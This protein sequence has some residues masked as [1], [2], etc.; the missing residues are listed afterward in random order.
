MKDNTIPLL[1]RKNVSSSIIYDTYQDAINAINSREKEKGQLFFIAYR[2]LMP[3]YNI[4]DKRVDVILAYAYG[5]QKSEY[6]ILNFCTSNL[7]WGVF[8]DELPSI[9]ILIHE[10]QFLYH[11]KTNHKWFL[12]FSLDGINRTVQ[13]LDAK[14]QTF[15]DIS[16]GNLWVSSN[17]KKVRCL[18]DVC[19]QEETLRILNGLEFNQRD[20]KET[21]P[22]KV[23]YIRNKPKLSEL[24]TITYTIRKEE[25][26]RRTNYNLYWTEYGTEEEIITGTIQLD[27]NREIK[28]GVLS[29]V[30]VNN[31]NL[32]PSDWNIGDEFLDLTIGGYEQSHVYIYMEP[33]V[34]RYT[35]G[36]GIQINNNII[37]VKV[38][39]ETG[40]TSNISWNLVNN[41][42]SGAM[43]S[44]DH[45]KITDFIP[46]NYATNS[47]LE[48]GE[49]IAGITSSTKDIIAPETT[50][51]TRGVE[52]ID[53]ILPEQSY[54]KE[55]ST[56]IGINGNNTT[57]IYT[58][59]LVST[60][61]N[62]YKPGNEVEG[63]K[64]DSTTG[65]VVEDQDYSLVWCRCIKSKVNTNYNEPI[66]NNGYVIS[67]ATIESVA[68]SN[69][70]PD[71]GNI[72]TPL[73][74]STTIFG[75]DSYIILEN[76]KVLLVSVLTTDLETLCI[77]LAWDG[78]N[79]S[80]YE[81]YEESVLD[82]SEYEVG[83]FSGIKSKFIEENNTLYLKDI[84]G[85]REQAENLGWEQVSQSEYSTNDINLGLEQGTT[86]DLLYITSNNDSLPC[87]YT[88]MVNVGKIT[89]TTNTIISGTLYYPK[90][91]ELINTGVSPEFE[92]KS[93]YGVE[94]LD[95]TQKVQTAN[96]D[97]YIEQTLTPSLIESLDNFRKNL[98]EKVGWKDIDKAIS[99]TSE[100]P[101]AN[102]VIKKYVD[103]VSSAIREK[104]VKDLSRYDI[105]G[106]PNTGMTTANCYVIYETGTYKLPLVYG[107]AIKNGVANTSSYVAGEGANM[108]AFVNYAGSIITYPYIENDIATLTKSVKEPILIWSETDGMITGMKL[109]KNE[110]DAC[111]YLQ[112]KVS[113]IPVDGSN[114]LIGIVDNSNPSD[115]IW[116]WHLWMVND[117][118]EL[119]PVEIRNKITD[120]TDEG[121]AIYYIMPVNLG[122]VGP[123][124]NQLGTNVY[125]QWGRK[126][127][128]PRSATLTSGTTTTVTPLY[129]DKT[130][131]VFGTADD[132]S[133]DK[134][135]GNSIRNP[136][137]FFSR[138]NNTNYNWFAPM[139]NTAATS[140]TIST[141]YNLWDAIRNAAQVNN[142]NSV[143]SIYDPCPPG[144]KVPS[145]DT[146]KGFTKTQSGTTASS[147]FNVVGSFSK[148]WKFM[149]YY[150]DNLGLLF[151]A[152]GY[153]ATASGDLAYVGGNGYSWSS[154]SSTQDYAYCLY[155]GSGN[156]YPVNG[157][158]RAGGFPVRP[159]LE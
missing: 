23:G 146:F 105:F 143:K 37:S 21:D 106:V 101:V 69:N 149:K 63:V 116:S 88:Q 156:V 71:V 121:S 96:K 38:D 78:K 47:K 99:N 13:E 35:P 93:V 118:D 12:V 117:V 134:T 138:Y 135:I 33:L 130:F 128:M 57:N 120:S 142:D 90:P 8:E 15:I 89:L 107:N 144:F 87:S 111:S 31:K 109:V 122:Y 150:E 28:S 50:K 79:S 154:A 20:W 98:E 41:D 137:L 19:T 68:V 29:T 133:A 81:E 84:L 131:G 5:N 60:G 126:D 73:Q 91:E 70:I 97:Y 85:K 100:N 124:A 115:I 3:N 157:N 159:I 39:T 158:S 44:E 32:V 54:I 58:F 151:P 22:E 9:D 76:D 129:G 45:R 153:R 112:F 66:Y 42:T 80:V 27:E 24:G 123:G 49:I 108:T 34:D 104:E 82:L 26:T 119:H 141:P 147:N 155:F 11:N 67:G 65:E 43:S 92:V 95:V 62:Q 152:S 2:S 75:T 18:N 25:T 64:I 139:S 55:I 36:N 113:S 102:N 103:E 46:E 145:R 30:T 4:P 77:R 127:P 83:C 148:G 59:K 40:L 114:A 14:P 136:H 110:G 10:Q 74:T 61:A 1:S 48:S 86:L 56:E 7:I 53:S 6:R 17:D 16:T 94:Y 125:Y 132:T 51:I 140:S 52:N 72:L